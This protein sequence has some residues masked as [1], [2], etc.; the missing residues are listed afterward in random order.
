M[1]KSTNKIVSITLSKEDYNNLEALN[2][3]FK[4]NNIQSSKSKIMAKA[5]NEYLTNIVAVGTRKLKSQNKAEQGED[6]IC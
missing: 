2:Q 1:I 5:F 6:K 4:K 3:A